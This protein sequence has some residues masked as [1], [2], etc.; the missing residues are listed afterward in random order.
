MVE[1]LQRR[2]GWKTPDDFTT[3][4][5]EIF[6]NAVVGWTLGTGYYCKPDVMKAIA[7]TCGFAKDECFVAVFEPHSLLD[8]TCEWHLVDITE[9]TVKVFH[10][11]Q[12]Y[13]ELEDMQPCDMTTA[14]FDKH[15][16]LKAKTK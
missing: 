7:D 10:G 16:V 14:M 2:Q 13:A 12:A 8:H 3:L 15:S 5:N 9:P 1:K 11:K 4:F 6:Y